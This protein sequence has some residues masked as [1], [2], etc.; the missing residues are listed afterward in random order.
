V[1]TKY[2]ELRDHVKSMRNDR[3]KAESGLVEVIGKIQ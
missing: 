1:K 3:K 2:K